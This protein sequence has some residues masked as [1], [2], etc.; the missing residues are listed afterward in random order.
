MR[1]RD[2]HHARRR[3]R[4][5]RPR[6][7]RD[8]SRHPARQHDRDHRGARR[9]AVAPGDRRRCSR[10]LIRT[11][12]AS[13]TT[14]SAR[15]TARTRWASRRSTCSSTPSPSTSCSTST[16]CWPRSR[17][18][19]S[20]T[21]CTPSSCSPCSRSRRRSAA[22]SARSTSRAAAAARGRHRC[23]EGHRAPG[24]LGGHASV[25]PVREAAD[26]RARPLPRARRPAPVRRAP[27]AHLRH[28][29]PCRRRRPREGGRR[30][31]RDARPPAAAARAERVVAVLARRAH[32]PRVD[33]PARVRRVPALRALPHASRITPTTHASSASSSGRAASPTT[34]TSG[35]TSAPTR[36][37]A[38]SRCGSATP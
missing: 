1:T 18:A 23:R 2:L 35:G 22:T 24:G 36:G 33:T 17:A 38:R 8:L 13:S 28:A 4:R 31:E 14:G 37:W 29:H 9:S 26:H 12:R 5:G 10:R 15:R 25:Q 27:R 19:T 30:A 6:P 3:L 32:G 20:R 34:R 16:P 21:S 11:S 7:R